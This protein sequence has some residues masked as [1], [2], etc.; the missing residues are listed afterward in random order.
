MFEGNPL[1]AR[2]VFETRDLRGKVAESIIAFNCKDSYQ[3]GVCVY[4][5]GVLAGL[6]GSLDYEPCQEANLRESLMPTEPHVARF[7]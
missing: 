7:A 2:W 4:F 5:C 3:Q 1:T 6:P